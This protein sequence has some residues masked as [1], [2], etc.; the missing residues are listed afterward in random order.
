MAAGVPHPDVDGIDAIPFSEID[1]YELGVFGA[2]RGDFLCRRLTQPGVI[3]RAVRGAVGR[4]C[5]YG[6]LRPCWVGSTYG[7]VFA[8]D[9][10]TACALIDSLV[11]CERGQ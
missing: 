11:P 2:P 8:D 10:A 9:A 3:G 6:Q 7:P 4:R 1:A 5:G